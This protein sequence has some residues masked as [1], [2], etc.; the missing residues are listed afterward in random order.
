MYKLQESKVKDIKEIISN[1]KEVQY[2][3]I[4]DKECKR[5]EILK[6]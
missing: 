6:M 1:I 3:H 5:D 2:V 4:G